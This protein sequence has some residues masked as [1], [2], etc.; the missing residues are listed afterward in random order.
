MYSVVWN[1]SVVLLSISSFIEYIINVLW[2][3][4]DRKLPI[5][6]RLSSVSGSRI[7][8]LHSLGIPLEF[9]LEVYPQPISYVSVVYISS[10]FLDSAE[11][12]GK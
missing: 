9:I 5:S 8:L 12:H 4:V 7:K 6:L 10:M 1:Q 11:P 3:V 2:F